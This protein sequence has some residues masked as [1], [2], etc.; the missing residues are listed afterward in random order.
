MCEL[1]LGLNI[2]GTHILTGLFAN[3]TDLFI[4]PSVDWRV[5][6]AI[7]EPIKFGRFSECKPNIN[8]TKCI[9]LGATK[10]NR[11]LLQNFEE[12]HGNC[13][14]NFIVHSFTALGI[15]FNNWSTV[16]RICELDFSKKR[17]IIPISNSYREMSDNQILAQLTYLISPLTR[18]GDI[19]SSRERPTTPPPILKWSQELDKN[20]DWCD[21]YSNLFFSLCNN[22]KLMQ[23][24][25]K[26]WHRIATCSTCVI[27]WKLIRIVLYVPSVT[28]NWK[29][30]P[31]FTW[32]VCTLGSS[33][34]KSTAS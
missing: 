24:H 34:V 29:Y 22:F 31:T 9:S 3:D 33:G 25:F 18:P 15:T 32:I 10:S 1:L 6:A 21:V 26:L 14:D 12:Q 2:S 28:G 17:Y 7:D 23:F 20:I 11:E 19:I 4:E 16:N 13:G 5:N 30:F 8:K 27:K